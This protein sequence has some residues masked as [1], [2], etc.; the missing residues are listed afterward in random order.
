MTQIFQKL[1]Y[2]PPGHEA[3]VTKTLGETRQST[4]HNLC[5]AMA[6]L[7]P[8]T[9][10]HPPVNTQ[11]SLLNKPF[12]QMEYAHSAVRQLKLFIHTGACLLVIKCAP[13]MHGKQLVLFVHSHGERQCKNWHVLSQ[14]YVYTA[15]DALTSFP[16]WLKNSRWWF[17]SDCS[18]PDKIISWSPLQF[19]LLPVYT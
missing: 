3:H 1:T 9:P 19:S 11:S 16:L 13:S 17:I 5:C 4:V 10:L 2:L 8:S 7:V 6:K 15:E 12:L 18:S 14:D